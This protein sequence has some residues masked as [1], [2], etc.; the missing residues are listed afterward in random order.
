MRPVSVA[1]T[2][3]AG[4]KGLDKNNRNNLTTGNAHRWELAWGKRGT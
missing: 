3:A 4:R 1:A 2:V